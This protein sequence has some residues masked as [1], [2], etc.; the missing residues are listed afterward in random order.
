MDRVT[1][2]GAGR[3]T[4]PRQRRRRP[5]AALAALAAVLA[6][7]ACSAG[8][9]SAT[10]GGSTASPA[11]AAGNS[12]LDP[13]TSLGSEPAPDFRLVNQFGQPMSLSQFRGKVVIL[14]FNDSVCTT[15]CPLTTQAMVEAKQL[16]G[17]AGNHVQLLGIDANPDATAVSDVM[18]YSRAHGMVNQWDFLTGTRAQLKAVWKAYHI[19]VQIERDEIDH[20]PALFVIDP[21]GRERAV[22]LTQMYY[23]GI[24]Q[25]AQILAREVAGLLPGHPA[26]THRGSL[27][28]ISG[29]KPTTHATLPGVPSGTVTLGPG[30]P[31]LLVFFATWVA[32]TSDLRGQL[33]TLNS[34]ATAARGGRLPAL[35]A[36]DEGATEPSTTAAAAFLSRLDTPLRYPVAVDTTGRV[37]DGYG[38][39][40]QPW[41][42]LV[43]ATGKTVWTHDGWIPLPGLEA[44]ARRA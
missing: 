33:R 14:A 35:V 7:A 4:C 2:G 9:G 31:R 34:Y 17:P 44:A 37:A 29:V 23:A 26:L 3:S 5:A 27:A 21:Q 41:Y 20:T 10:G 42:V 16:L 36:L 24:E 18:S 25:Q 39:Q 38:V 32:G 30:R 11:D 6:L 8:G 15:I 12:K 19:D 22:Y 43:S 40:D 28:L 1:N 13:G